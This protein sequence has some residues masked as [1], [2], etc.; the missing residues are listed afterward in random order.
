MKGTLILHAAQIATP[1]G[2][3]ALHGADMNRLRIIEDGAI[4][5]VGGRIASVGTTD[6]L[7][8][9]LDPAGYEIVDASGRCIVP[10]FVDSHTHFVFGGYRADEFIMRL[11]GASYMD[12]MK[13]GG[14]IAA[15]VSATRAA[16]FDEL[17][18]AGLERLAEMLS[19]GITT[20]EGKSGYGLDCQTELLQLEVMQKLRSEQPVDI[21]R[22]FMGA[23][24]I[25]EQFGGDEEGYVDYLISRV[26]PCVAEKGLASFCDVFCEE[27]VFSPQ[28]A[29]R[30]LKA[31]KAMGLAPKI[32]ADEIV[33]LGGAE[34]A[35]ALWAVSADHLLA[36]SDEG[37]GALSQ[38][39]TVATLLPCT[40]FSLDR[41]FAPARRLI[42]SGCAVALATDYNPGSCFTCSIPLTFA[43]AAIK[44]HMT[45]EEA[46]TALTLNGAAAIGKAGEIG[47]LE[48][49]K[50]ADIVLLAYPDYK[51][52][53]YHTAMNCVQSVFKSGRRVYGA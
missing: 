44:M 17:Y 14:G 24:A 47:S 19:M 7:L 11:A 15:T 20:V 48:V 6:D 18:E 28:S 23:H 35:A 10:G 25:P 1:Q 40:A 36:V 13:A 33:P 38:S 21:V 42:D 34:L 4:C 49:G 27:G 46:L 5:I 3:S 32:H 16:G 39:Q 37:I 53:V 8:S 51:F 29:A 2:K 52:L 22:T 30:L 41:P 26:L 9:R 12:I 50:Q 43:L 45:P 31:A